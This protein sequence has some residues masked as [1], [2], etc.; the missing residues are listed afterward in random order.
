M[1]EIVIDE[2]KRRHWRR[3]GVMG[4][5]EP[6]V[7]TEPLAALQIAFETLEAGHAEAVDDSVIKVMEGRQ[8][9]ACNAAAVTA[10]EALRAKQVDGII[11]GCTEIPLMIPEV[12]N[13]SGL[14]NPAQLLAE[15]AVRYAIA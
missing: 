6:V 13:G 2:V 10:I 3:V 9:A 14:I 7:Y 5:R 1:I 12:A 8:D 15:E 11:L 4:F